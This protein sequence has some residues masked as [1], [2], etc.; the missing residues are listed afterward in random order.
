MLVLMQL[1]ATA[2]AGGQEEAVAAT[3][4]IYTK[5]HQFQF[6]EIKCVKFRSGGR[7]DLCS[8]LNC[9]NF[10]TSLHFGTKHAIRHHLHHNLE[11]VWFVY[12]I[13]DTVC[14]LQYVGS[15]VNINRRFSQQKTGCNRK[16]PNSTSGSGLQKH[17]LS[18]CPG[19][20][21]PNQSHL[22]VTLI[23]SISVDPATLERVGHSG[24]GCV[25]QE[26]LRLKTLEDQHIL[27]LG[28]YQRPHGLNECNEIRGRVRT[29]YNGH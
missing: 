14:E 19:D 28:T 22:I 10:V 25:C 3:G 18:G 15:T 24:V 2:R 5:M 9:T 17:F 4:D 20:N 1:Y 16:D 26:C 6:F 12:L 7:C 21:I 23:D 29:N 13:E 11:N 27:A 8:H